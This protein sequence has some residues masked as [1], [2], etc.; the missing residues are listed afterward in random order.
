MGTVPAVVKVA[1]LCHHVSPSGKPTTF[2][3]NTVAS[4]NLGCRLDLRKIALEAWNTEYKLK[5]RPVLIMRIR[6]PRTTALVF[7]N[8][9]ILCSGAADELKA[10]VASRKFAR[11]IQKLGFDAHF[12]NFKIATM[13]ATC[14][15]GFMIRLEGLLL[16]TRGLA[17][18]E[19][20]LF[21]GLTYRPE[22]PRV[23][24]IIFASGKIVFTG[25][26]TKDAI[27]EAFSD[28]YPLLRTCRI[29]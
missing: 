1:C 16:A 22:H 13:V 19:P 12:L 28:I 3:R 23:T 2:Y 17:S 9:N 4:L 18:Y 20:E 7:E 26:T 25:S 29:D 11:I 5:R 10:K 6:E 14:D 21:P 24:V 27:Y 15:I 8:G